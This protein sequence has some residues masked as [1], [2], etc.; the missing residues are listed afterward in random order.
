[1]GKGQVHSEGITLFLSRVPDGTQRGLNRSTNPAINR[2]ATIGRPFGTVHASYDS[3]EQLSPE[4]RCRLGSTP[5]VPMARPA[6]TGAGVTAESVPSH[7]ER[8]NEPP[9]LLICAS[10]TA[11]SLGSSAGAGRFRLDPWCLT[12]GASMR[13]CRIAHLVGTPRRRL[14]HRLPLGFARCSERSSEATW[15]LFANDERQRLVLTAIRAKEPLLDERRTNE[16]YLRTD[17][18]D[19]VV[20]VSCNCEWIRLRAGN[21]GC[22]GGGGHVGNG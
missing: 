17:A 9:N 21:G 11:C 12:S 19:D 13:L 5:E 16:L 18:V 7:N 20:L 15:F 3:S 6:G 2:W 1:M 4:R 10:L 8:P 22:R 14:A